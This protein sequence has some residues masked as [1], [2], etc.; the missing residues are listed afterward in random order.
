MNPHLN[1]GI[2]CRIASIN[3]PS[4]ILA[5]PTTHIVY[6]CPLYSGHRPSLN[7]QYK[8]PHVMHNQRTKQN[9]HWKHTT[10]FFFFFVALMQDYRPYIQHSWSKLK[11][12]T[13]Q[14]ATEIGSHE[15]WPRLVG[16]LGKYHTWLCPACSRKS[17]Q[18]FVK[19]YFKFCKR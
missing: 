8:V 12:T 19:A 3:T 10:F 17:R 2:R 15:L 6:C 7:A 16:S 13:C 11:H 4:F 18:V 5:Y 1:R 14:T 9:N